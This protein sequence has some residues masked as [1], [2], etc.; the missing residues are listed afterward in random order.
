MLQVIVS[1]MAAGTAT[2]QE[3]TKVVQVHEGDSSWWIVLLVMFVAAVSFSLGWTVG[4][5]SKNEKIAARGHSK[6]VAKKMTDKSTSSDEP[7]HENDLTSEL[8]INQV[9]TVAGTSG[10]TEVASQ[11]QCTYARKHS[12]PRFRVLPDY[13]QG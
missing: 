10:N 9:S 2:A 11:S 13:L 8:L 5:Y 12:T 3:C 1:A 4:F 6:A 7:F